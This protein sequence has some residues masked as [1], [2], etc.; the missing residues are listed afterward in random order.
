MHVV[1][2]IFQLWLAPM[3]PGAHQVGMKTTLQVGSNAWVK[4]RVQQPTADI[5][6]FDV[7]T[8]QPRLHAWYETDF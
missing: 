6:R 3:H 2:S 4:I 5:S 7:G 8:E 1:F